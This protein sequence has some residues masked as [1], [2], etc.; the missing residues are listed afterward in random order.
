MSALS[1]SSDDEDVVSTPDHVELLQ[2]QPP[3]TDAF[4]GSQLEFI[5][6]PRTD[7][8]HVVRERLALVGA[9]GRDHV[10]H[11]VDH[12]PL[13]CR[14]A[15]MDAVVAVGEIVAVLVEHAD[16]GTSGN[17]DPPVPVLHLGRLG[18]KAFGHGF[19]PSRSS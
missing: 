6:V 5:A 1:F 19:A 7:E 11:T 13:A 10:D 12:E 4:A 18:N 2:S 15:G 8:M 17:D 3:I 9:V 14:T 16:F